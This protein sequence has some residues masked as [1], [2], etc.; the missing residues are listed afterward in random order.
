MEMQL[1]KPQRVDTTFIFHEW[2]SLKSIPEQK[3]TFPLNFSRSTT[4]ILRYANFS[5]KLGKHETSERELFFLK[6]ITP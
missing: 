1:T 5:T 4:F 6:N 3:S 2:F